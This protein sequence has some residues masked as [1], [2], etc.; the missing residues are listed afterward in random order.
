MKTA[1]R[2]YQVG[3]EKGMELVAELN[4]SFMEPPSH[5]SKGK[6]NPRLG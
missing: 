4:D 1:Q 2:W 6:T 5:F 3:L